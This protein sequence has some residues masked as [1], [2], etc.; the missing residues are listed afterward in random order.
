M[1]TANNASHVWERL[2]ALAASGLEIRT[3]SR[4]VREGDVFVALP[5]ATADGAQF[6]PMALENGAAWVVAASGAHWP[7]SAKAVLAVHGNPR[8]ALGELARARYGTGRL[9]LSLTAVTG[10][11]GKTTI[12]YL[13]EHM[14]NVAG[15][16]AGVVGTVEY[17]WH[18]HQE[19][20]SHTTPDC[21]KIHSLLAQMAQAGV[22]AAAMEVSSH[23]LDQERVAGLTFDVAAITNVTQDHLDYHG[24]MEPYFQA[25]RRLFTTY[26]S[27]PSKAVIN[28]DDS[29]CRKLLEEFPEALGYGLHGLSDY[30]RTA[31]GRFLE[32]RVLENTSKGLLLEMRLGSERWRLRSPMIGAFNA[33]NLLAAQ[34]IAL[35]LGLSHRELTRLGSC[36][37][38]PGRLER[39]P[40]ARGVHV[41]VDYAHTPD[42]L[43]NVLKA[44]RSLDFKRIITVFGCGGDRDRTKRPLMARAVARYSDVCVLT[45]DNPRHEDPGAIMADA[46]PGLADAVQVISHADRRQAIALALAE[47]GHQDVVLI[48]GKGH[49]TYQQVGSVKHPFNDVQVVRELLG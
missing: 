11:N 3:D 23:A 6:I 32:G 8:Q 22:R 2:L 49:E 18:G 10:T 45:S 12:T 38:A 15:S 9:P 4:L 13:V 14:L 21:L 46:M 35:N 44:L 31:Q 5:G 43:K 28:A 7:A 37:G 36:M 40:N 16:R 33:A 41:F 20:A 17:R 1:Q 30:G 27:D 25:K 47:A 48:A 39:V 19:P 24:G 42:A 34:G 26:L 29:Y